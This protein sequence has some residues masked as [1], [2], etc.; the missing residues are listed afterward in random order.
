MTMTTFHFQTHVSD[1]GMITLPAL[2]ETLHGAN[3]TVKIDQNVKPKRELRSDRICG[4]WGEKEDREDIDR[5]VAAIHEGR[6]L[7]TER[8]PL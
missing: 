2:P 8:K 5:I 6:L 3:V 4:A 7:G 1:S